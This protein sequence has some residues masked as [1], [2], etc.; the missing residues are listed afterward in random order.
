[1]KALIFAIVLAICS[2]PVSAQEA[3]TLYWDDLLPSNEETVKERLSKSNQIVSQ[4]RATTDAAED[5][6]FLVIKALNGYKVRMPGFIVPLD[7]S[8]DGRLSDFLLVP[9]QGA[10]IHEPPPPPNQVVHAK[11]DT[12]QQFPN[13]WTPV[14]L[15]GTLSTE[16]YL[17]YLGDAAYTMNIES[18]EVYRGPE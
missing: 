4:D 8:A 10:C 3:I 1:M 13:L 12:P 16:Q 18:W 11:T 6:D 14:W 5:N 15:T 7:F 9:Y 17:N 2:G